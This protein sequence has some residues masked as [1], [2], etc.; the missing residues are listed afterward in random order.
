M[1]SEVESEVISLIKDLQTRIIYLE[2]KIDT[3]VRQS[4]EGPSRGQ[5]RTQAPQNYGRP[6]HR[7]DTRENRFGPRTPRSGRSFERTRSDEDRGGSRGKKP[8]KPGGKKS[9]SSAGKK[10]PGKPRSSR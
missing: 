7:E 6:Q 10:R 2:R 9:F 4:S 1:E 8:S 5:G 3:L